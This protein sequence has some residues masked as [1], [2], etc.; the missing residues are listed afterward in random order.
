MQVL[1]NDRLIKQRSTWGGRLMLG[2]FGLVIA[3]LPLTFLNP[4]DPTS[5]MLAYAL[6]FGGFIVV[7]IGGG[8][9]SKWRVR[10]RPDEALAKSLKGLDNKHR[11]YNYILPAEHVLLTP[12]GITVFQVRRI[13][14]VISCVGD[15]WTHKRSILRRLSLGADEQVGEPTHDAQRDLEAI[16]SFLAKNGKAG[17]I[18]LDALVLFSNPLAQLTVT[19]PSV[20]VL[21][22]ANAKPY[23]RQRAA[24]GPKLDM[25]AWNTL[26]DLL[27]DATEEL[28]LSLE[29]EE[30]PA[31]SDA[32]ARSA[33]ASK[34]KK[35]ETTPA[36][37]AG[38]GKK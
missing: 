20:P 28:G 36:G 35:V 18:P 19:D 5:M 10:P 23:M 12:T 4:T 33:G 7:N 15:K 32:P 3:S 26:A 6:L 22:G 30:A 8:I 29:G 17:N 38:K 16:G 2:G 24:K 14:G 9:S 1:S 31:D 11:L 37:K 13:A 21:T 27:D 34:G 25:D